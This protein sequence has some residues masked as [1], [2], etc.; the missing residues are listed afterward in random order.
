MEGKTQETNRKI[1]LPRA[2]SE[3]C[4]EIYDKATE[5]RVRRRQRRDRTSRRREK[6]PRKKCELN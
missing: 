3:S 1:H 5:M 2:L 6:K 4:W